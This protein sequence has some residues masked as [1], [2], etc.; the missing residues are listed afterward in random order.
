MYGARE[1]LHLSEAG[2]LAQ[3][4]AHVH[5]L[6]PG[7]RSSDRHWHEEEV[8]FL[9]MLSGE[10]TVIEEDGPHL[11]RP[12]DAACWPADAANA[13]QGVNRSGAL[14]SYLIL[15]SGA[16]PDVVHYPDRG[17]ILYDFFG[18]T[19]RLQ[20]TDGT[21]IKEGNPDRGSVV[22]VG[23]ARTDADPYSGC[24]ANSRVKTSPSVPKVPRSRPSTCASTAPALPVQM[25]NESRPS[26]DREK[27]GSAIRS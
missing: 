17:E 1:S 26:K 9:Y 12:G 24:A 27:P 14:Y 25:L 13:H 3:F 2:G 10:A 22:S 20:R 21:L 19:W 4:V 18:G 8:E 15:G 11:L 23:H 5:T 7:S 16:V 6:Q